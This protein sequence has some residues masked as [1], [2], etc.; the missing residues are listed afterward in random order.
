MEIETKVIVIN[1][2]NVDVPVKLTSHQENSF[3]RAH[4]KYVDPFTKKEEFDSLTA[5]SKIEAER[6]LINNLTTFLKTRAQT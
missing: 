1:I 4:A 5:V 6:Q 2:D 3:W